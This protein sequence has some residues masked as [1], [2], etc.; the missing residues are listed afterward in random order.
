MPHIIW[1]DMA[2]DNYQEKDPMLFEFTRKTKR[3]R[4]NKYGQAHWTLEEHHPPS[5]PR[6]KWP[7]ASKNTNFSSLYS[8]LLKSYEK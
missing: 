1:S 2:L 6:K 4:K 3:L 7:T 5:A 8:N